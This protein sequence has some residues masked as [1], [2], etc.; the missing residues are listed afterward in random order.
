[1]ALRGKNGRKKPA[2]KADIV[3]NSNSGLVGTGDNLNEAI[4]QQSTYRTVPI[5]DVAPDPDNIRQV[6]I[7]MEDLRN[8]DA[9]QDEGVQAEALGIIELSKTVKAD[10]QIQP[11]VGYQESGERIWLISGERRWWAM[12][13]AG[14]DKMDLMVFAG[15]PQNAARIQLI[16]N[17]QRRD[18][19]LAGM[20][21]GLERVLN[22]QGKAGKAVSTGTELIDLIG[23]NRSEAFR[24]WAV[25]TGPQDV[26]DAIA[27]ERID[28]IS[29]ARDVAKIES[30]DERRQVLTADSVVKALQDWQK[31]QNDRG[32]QRTGQGGRKRQTVSLGRVKSTSVVRRLLEGSG[33]SIDLAEVDWDDPTAVTRAWR[34][35]LEDLEARLNESK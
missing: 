13:L 34:A 24:W 31:R 20:L 28:S 6:R 29:L 9:I 4:V 17:M 11:G 23:M 21:R 12:R 14:L 8:P 2:S 1:M 33:T 32:S 19:S 25:L 27:A 26:R 15:R 16:E 3:E 7:T 10:G 22:E 5:E 30:E 35:V 18:V